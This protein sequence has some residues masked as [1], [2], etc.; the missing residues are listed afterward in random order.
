MRYQQQYAN[1]CGAVALMCALDELGVTQ[2]PEAVQWG[3]G[4]GPGGGPFQAN[5]QAEMRIY[6]QVGTGVS[7]RLCD[8]GYSMPAQLAM[9]AHTFGLPLPTVYVTPGIYGTMLTTFYKNA[10]ENAQA[11]G[12]PVVQGA[13]PPLQP[14]QRALRVV[15]VMKVVGLHYVLERPDG[16]FMDPGDGQDFASFAQLNSSWLKS[17]ADTGISILL[18]SEWHALEPLL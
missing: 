18:T 15:A 5:T 3:G 2:Y 4:T 8:R 9:M 16:S 11:L 6:G 12:I 7:Q 1:S 17:Y 10:M 13:R 14:W